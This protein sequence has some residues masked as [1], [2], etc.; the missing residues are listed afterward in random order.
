[1]RHGA[2]MEPSGIVREIPLQECLRAIG[3]GL[4]GHSV[5]RVRL[6]I[7]ADGI[8]VLPSRGLPFRHYGWDDLARLARSQREQ[9][10]SGTPPRW[11]DP[12]SLTRWPVLLRTT[13]LL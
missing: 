9:R 13:G 6:E 12:W 1:M 11:M 4:E 5:P 3:N 2:A 8:S 7:G 10:R